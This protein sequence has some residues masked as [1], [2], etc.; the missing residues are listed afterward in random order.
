MA[1]SSLHSWEIAPN[2]PG[3]QHLVLPHARLLWVNELGEKL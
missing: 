3:S 2:V 1:H